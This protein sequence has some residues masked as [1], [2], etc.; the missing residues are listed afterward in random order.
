MEKK[1]MLSVRAAVCDARRVTEETLSG[2]DKVQLRCG[3]L[4]T[5]P[6]SREALS[7]Y[8][9][10]INA[11]S[12]QEIEGGA[13]V[14]TVNG[15]TEIVPG[16]AAPD[17]K[18]YLMVN[19]KLD[20]APGCEAEL[21]NYVGITVNGKVSCPKSIMPLLAGLMM[22]G[23]IES[24]PD[25]CIRLKR[26]AVLDRT[27]RLRARE[28]ALYYAAGRIA[29][30]DPALDFAAL[31]A[32]NVRFSTPSLLVAE[33][34]AE[35][36][37]PLFDQET[38]IT[39]LPDGCAL[40]KDDADM[41]EELADRCG[42]KLYLLGSLYVAEGKGALL[43]RFTFLRVAGDVQAVRSEAAAVRSSCAEYQRLRTMGGT[44]IRNRSTPVTVSRAVLEQAE[45]GLSVESCVDVCIE[46][47]VTTALL[48]ERL[49]SIANCVSVVCTEEQ[50]AAVEAVTENVVNLGAEVPPEEPREDE[51]VIKTAFYQM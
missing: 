27:F 20:I 6:E 25:G 12:I 4:L 51:A 41:D 9:A 36:A 5:T 17:C 15:K 37:V 21:K 31:A 13:K 19:G 32:K 40:V 46:E 48:R 3:V 50:R 7:R 30:L 18:L 26:T 22:N 10:E 49:V 33:S 11:A 47:D 2:Y 39:V 1:A 43:E 14:T 16:Q 28:G 8:G 44:V 45:S 35:A 24:Y 23:V 42:G 29:A 34:L 38:E